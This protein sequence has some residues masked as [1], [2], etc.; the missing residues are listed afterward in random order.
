MCNRSLQW[1]CKSSRWEANWKPFGVA[2]LNCIC[3]ATRMP[4]RWQTDRFIRTTSCETVRS[5]TFEKDLLPW[6]NNDFT[7]Q[8]QVS[9]KGGK[10]IW[11]QWSLTHGLDWS[12]RSDL[13]TLLFFRL[14]DAMIM[15]LLWTEQKSVFITQV[16]WCH[17]LCFST[18]SSVFFILSRVLVFFYGYLVVFMSVLSV[19]N[20]KIFCNNCS[21]NWDLLM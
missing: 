1:K 18:R 17:S 3:Y 15:I 12:L 7:F 13:I 8:Q 19:V 11:W 14:V 2:D 6:F 16:Q 9:T 4:L 10:L 20:C 5:N 21:S